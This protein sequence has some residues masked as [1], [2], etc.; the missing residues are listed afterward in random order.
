MHKRDNDLGCLQR[1]PLILGNGE[2]EDGQ[3]LD[4][5][6]RA[7]GDVAMDRFRAQVTQGWVGLKDPIHILIARCHVYL[8]RAVRQFDRGRNILQEKWNVGL[9]PYFDLGQYQ[10]LII[11]LAVPWHPG[12]ASAPIVDQGVHRVKVH[13]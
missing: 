8:F 11:I 7:Q 1:V 4:R 12:I 5:L 13:G 2:V 3:P 6:P 9:I 10:Q